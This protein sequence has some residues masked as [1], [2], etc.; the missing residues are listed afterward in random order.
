MSARDVLTKLKLPARDAYDLPSSA[1]RFADGGQYRIEIPSC[2]GP[3][4]MQAVVAEAAAR[5]DQRSIA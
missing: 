2:E 4:A 5:Q 3:K 1:K